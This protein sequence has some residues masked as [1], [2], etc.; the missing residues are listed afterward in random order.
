ML[1]KPFHKH[2][3]LPSLCIDRQTK[4]QVTRIEVWWFPMIG[5]ADPPTLHVCRTVHQSEQL[6]CCAGPESAQPA[7][8]LP[9]AHVEGQN[10]TLFL[11]DS[12]H[13]QFFC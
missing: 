4:M 13:L 3:I 7:I 6:V 11:S 9:W 1:S 8:T 12:S 2:K 5:S 10:E